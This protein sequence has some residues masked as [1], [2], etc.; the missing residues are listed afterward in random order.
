[1]KCHVRNQQQ[2][3]GNGGY[4][5]LATEAEKDGEGGD[6]LPRAGDPTRRGMTDMHVSESACEDPQLLFYFGTGRQ[7]AADHLGKLSRLFWM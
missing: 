6:A 4:S 5:F 1:M 2:R 3:Q 7:A